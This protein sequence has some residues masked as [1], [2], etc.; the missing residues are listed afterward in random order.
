M[1]A[2]EL[3]DSLNTTASI[4]GSSSLINNEQLQNETREEEEEEDAED[5][6]DDDDV[7]D[8]NDDNLPSE[9]QHRNQSSSSSSA[10]YKREHR[11]QN[12]Q[13]ASSASDPAAAAA[14]FQ[15]T[16]FGVSVTHHVTAFITW[17][18][19]PDAVCSRGRHVVGYQLRYRRVGDSD[20]VSHHLAD[21]MLVLDQLMPNQRYRYQLQYVTEPPGESL[22]SQEAELD[23]TD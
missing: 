16:N 13:T 1:T 22:W 9:S 4:N 18:Q 11:H 8:D 21:N 5:D 12:Q 2:G 15:H 20:Y 10:K 14:D 6:D 23:T 17:P 7:G 3:E 19:S